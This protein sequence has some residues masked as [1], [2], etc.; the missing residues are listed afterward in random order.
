MSGV[1]NI[2][3]LFIPYPHDLIHIVCEECHDKVE[4]VE[5]LRKRIGKAMSRANA[6]D[7]VA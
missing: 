7:I 5:K 3:V 1:I 6:D 4:E 2:I